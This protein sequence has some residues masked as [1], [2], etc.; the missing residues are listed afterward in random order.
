MGAKAPTPRRNSGEIEAARYPLLLTHVTLSP[1]LTVT[2]EGS[3]TSWPESEPSFT[4]GP[5]RAGA[6]AIVAARAEAV[7]TSDE[8]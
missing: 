5:A 6:A 4:V 2:S 3:K 7:A 8:D 1:T